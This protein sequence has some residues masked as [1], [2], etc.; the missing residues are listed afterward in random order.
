MSRTATSTEQKLANLAEADF[1]F[2][3]QWQTTGAWMD[4]RFRLHDGVGQIPLS[5]A[6]STDFTSGSHGYR[7]DEEGEDW[8]GCRM[9]GLA[10]FD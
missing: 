7:V 4:L 5:I 1:Y 3:L 9:S 8:Q 6:P 2:R 10:P